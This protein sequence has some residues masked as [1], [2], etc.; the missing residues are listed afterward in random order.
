MQGKD[1]KPPGERPRGLFST[2]IFDL[3]S[4][5]NLHLQLSVYAADV[6]WAGYTEIL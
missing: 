3:T 2:Y 1:E 5:S 6:S 4:F